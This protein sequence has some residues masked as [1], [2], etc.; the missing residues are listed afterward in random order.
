MSLKLRT[1]S[2]QVE[3]ASIG[4][5][6]FRPYWKKYDATL[7]S[8]TLLWSLTLSCSKE[9]FDGE[10]WE[11][12]STFDRF[13]LPVD[14]W[15]GLENLTAEL[16]SGRCYVIGHDSVGR[17]VL[18]LGKRT[19]SRFQFACAGVCDVNWDDEFGTDVPFTVKARV[20]F[21]GVRVVGT[22]GDD[23]DSLRKFLEAHFRIDKLTA[24]PCR[25]SGTP[26]KA[27]KMI[28]KVFVPA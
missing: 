18:K 5:A 8:D 14:T 27:K 23:D 24:N 7:I 3:K 2:F 1:R 21:E 26:S 22:T 11:P 16:E 28:E 15:L 20:D 25:E 6:L 19:G 17:T 12:K 10:L 4:A 9:K 13:Q